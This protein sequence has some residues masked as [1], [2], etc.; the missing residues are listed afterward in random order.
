MMIVH[1]Y[2]HTLSPS[3]SLIL[4]GLLTFTVPE[5][6][7]KSSRNILDLQPGSNTIVVAKAGVV[8]NRWERDEQED[9]HVC[10]CACYRC[11]TSSV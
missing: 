5:G 3:L 10:Q 8:L 11:A 9:G 7:F 6:N 2:L 1:I 4:D